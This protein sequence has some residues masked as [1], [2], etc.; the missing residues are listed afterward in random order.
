MLPT[1]IGMRTACSFW[2]TESYVDFDHL[3]GLWLVD[4]RMAGHVDEE[5]DACLNFFGLEDE[6]GVGDDQQAAF[7][8]DRLVVGVFEVVFRR[9]GLHS[10][11]Q[12]LQLI[13]L[14]SSDV[15]V[16]HLAVLTQP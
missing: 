10:A 12:L 6:A 1:D 5:L 13:D 11:Q 15:Y 4:D 9:H 14:S 8:I 16:W 7:V 2:L 3:F